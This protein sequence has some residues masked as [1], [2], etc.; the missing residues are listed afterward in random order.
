MRQF[1]KGS[2]SSS[3]C[4]TAAD[5]VHSLVGKNQWL[6]AEAN[7]STPQKF[8]LASVPV[9]QIKTLKYSKRP[10][11]W[12]TETIV[13]RPAAHKNTAF[14]RNVQKIRSQFWIVFWARGACVA[15]R[16]EGESAEDTATASRGALGS[17]MLT[18][19]CINVWQ[20]QLTRSASEKLRKAF[21][22]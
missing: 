11:Q 16:V 20:H 2:P 22:L 6:T 10:T 7:S 19:Y 9:V 15:P 12:V 8:Q 1:W 18:F 5:L 21:S 13:L 3:I 17:S 4:E 14:D